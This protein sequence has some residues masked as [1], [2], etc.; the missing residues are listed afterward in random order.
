MDS[1]GKAYTLSSLMIL[2]SA[3]WAT[4]EWDSTTITAHNSGPYVIGWPGTG[5]MYKGDRG[6]F[7]V[8]GDESGEI[9]VERA[10]KANLDWENG[11]FAK[12]ELEFGTSTEDQDPLV[13]LMGWVEELKDTGK[14]LGVF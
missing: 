3:V 5:H 12:W 11:H 8:T 10:M 1:G 2:R 9:H 7:E 4:K 13:E 14:E 6:S